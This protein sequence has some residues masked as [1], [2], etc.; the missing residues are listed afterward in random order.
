VGI[1][2]KATATRAYPTSGESLSEYAYS[3]IRKR[4]VTLAIP[5]GEP[6]SEGQLAT[7][8][9]ISKTPVREALSRLQHEGLVEVE[10][11]T[12]YRATPV[13]VGSAKDLLSLRILLEGEA[14]AL[15][16]TRLRDG[17][18]DPALVDMIADLS[19][20][21]YDPDDRASIWHY[22]ETN[23]QFHVGIAQ[24]G[25]NQYL[26]DAL[27]RVFILCERLLHA[28]MALTTRQRDVLHDHEEIF[29]G[30][31]SGDP[32]RARA[33][34]VRQAEIGRNL[35]VDALLSSTSVLRTSIEIPKPLRQ[36]N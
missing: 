8:L 33:I 20:L 15:A 29:M 25:G 31:T 19:K 28:G 24:I 22:L 32:D 11:R 17:T 36:S 35:I 5:P 26:T 6:F 7:E 16:A 9:Q 18:T 4:L 21:T 13:T 14:A 10:P 27:V 23:T 12:G 34:A 3:I 1:E 2:S 30:V